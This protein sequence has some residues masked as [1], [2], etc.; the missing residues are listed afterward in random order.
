V[1]PVR[2]E[3]GSFIPEDDILNIHVACSVL[4]LISRLNYAGLL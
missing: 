2:Y 4:H 3:L 1:F